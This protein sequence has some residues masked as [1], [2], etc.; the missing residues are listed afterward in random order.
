[1][2][3]PLSHAQQRT[4]ATK[5]IRHAEATA[6]HDDRAFLQA[7]RDHAMPSMPAPSGGGARS[8]GLPTPRP[9]DTGPKLDADPRYLANVRALANRTKQNARIIGGT[10]VVGKEWDDCVAVGDDTRFGCTGTLIAP[11]VVLTAGHCEVLHTRVLVGND[12]TKTGGEIRVVSHVRHPGWTTQLKNDL[13]LLILEK[14][15]PAVKPR[16]IATSKLIDAATDARVVGF[17]TTDVGGTMGF[18]IKQQ[19]DVPIVSAACRGKVNGRADSAVYACHVGQELVAGKPLLL[20]DTCRGDSGGPL[21][22][23]DARG[24]WF[25]AGVTSRGTG[26][27]TN[28]CG[29]GGLYTRVDQYSAWITKTIAGARAKGGSRAAARPARK[30]PKTSAKK[31][32]RKG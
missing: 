9:T 27:T 24:N 6:A 5:A 20:H 8:L 21:Y 13:M 15:A 10:G 1:M 22:V 19:T 14:A 29:D 18:G 7:L 11:N 30:R 4:I 25:L 17:G 3:K 31:R 26:Q 23:A 16:A 2:S 12:V 32:P 28:L